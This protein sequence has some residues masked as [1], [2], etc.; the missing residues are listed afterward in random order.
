M[1]HEAFN[2]CVFD[3]VKILTRSVVVFRNAESVCEFDG[4]IFVGGG[5]L[6]DLYSS[7]V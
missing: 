2:I 7:R 3:G 4:K 5:N 1:Y 6:N